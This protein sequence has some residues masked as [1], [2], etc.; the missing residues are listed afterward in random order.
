M[1]RQQRSLDEVQKETG[2]PDAGPHATGWPTFEVKSNTVFQ[3]I[4]NWTV[5]A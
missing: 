5:D 4:I 1:V 3:S 2:S